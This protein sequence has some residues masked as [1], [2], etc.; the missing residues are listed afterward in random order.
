[1][2]LNILPLGAVRACVV[3]FKDVRGIRHAAEVEA[4]SLYEAVVLSASDASIRTG[5]SNASA[6]APCSTLKF[7]SQAKSKR[8]RFNRSKQGRRP[9]LATAPS[10]CC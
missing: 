10:R 8:S 1:V 4:E 9:V 6:R 2:N 7:R 3:S 5:G